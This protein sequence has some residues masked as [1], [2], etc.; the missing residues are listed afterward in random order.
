MNDVSTALE[1]ARSLLRRTTTRIAVVGASN[2]PSKFGNIIVK[3]LLR[4]GYT[5]VP[6]N[7]HETTI[8]GLAVTVIGVLLIRPSTP[9]HA[10]LVWLGAQAFVRHC[11][12]SRDWS[13][14]S[15]ASVQAIQR[16]KR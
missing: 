14:S 3:D 7:L 13:H 4:R 15:S 8:A 2:S 11:V 5:V 6:V 1:A 16:D 10:V 12:R 9:L